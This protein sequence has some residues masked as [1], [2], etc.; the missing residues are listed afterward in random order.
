MNIKKIVYKIQSRSLSFCAYVHMLR[1]FSLVFFSFIFKIFYMGK[2]FRKG[3]G[4][5]L[6]HAMIKEIKKSVKTNGTSK[7]A[8]MAQR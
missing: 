5:Q 6:A 1:L 7:E 2:Q 4:L 8:A 3:S